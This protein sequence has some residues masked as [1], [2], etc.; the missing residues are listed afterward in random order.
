MKILRVIA[1]MNPTSGGPC[2]GIRNSVPELEKLGVHNEVVCL[3]DPNAAFL[4]K[5]IFPIHAIGP[6]KSPWNYN[7]KLLPWL[8]DN[9]GQFDVVIVHGLWLYHSYAVKK[10]LCRYKRLHKQGEV[11]VPKLFIMPHGMLDP[12]FQQAPGRKL[13]ALRNWAYWKLIEG[14]IVNEADGVLF[15]CEAELQLAREPFQPYHP[16]REINIGYGIT[17]PSAFTPAMRSAF[18]EK[19]PE[20]KNR[21]YVLFLSRIHEK[22]GVGLLIKAYSEIARNTIK[23]KAELAAANISTKEAEASEL[24]DSEWPILVVAGPG[25]ETPYGESIQQLAGETNWLDT[26]VLFSGMLTGDAKWG[27]FYGCEAFVL[28]S[29]QENFGIA[30][31]E[32]L[33]CG[34]PVLISD[35]VNIWQE[36]EAAGGG[37]VADDTLEGT[38][39]LL[40]S[41][42]ILSVEEKQAMSSKAKTCYEKFFA[43]QPHVLRLLEA[44]NLTI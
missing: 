12:Y 40:K 8:M 37:L 25:L 24:Q 28:P 39:R 30:V 10:A 3:D 36:I 15:T 5:D 18:L 14:S 32:A 19:C 11:K 38:I 4:G 2:Q 41:W 6:G 22:K 27:A 42:Q 33:A 7:K 1:S 31:V 29:H 44:I 34:K 21:P 35:Q 43:I 16:R 9:L 13:K 26:S 23:L 17:E 20:L